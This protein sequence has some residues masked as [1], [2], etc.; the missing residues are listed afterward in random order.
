[1]PPTIALHAVQTNKA[2][3]LIKIFVVSKIV[4]KIRGM[5]SSSHVW[6]S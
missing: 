6:Q 5:D 4:H 2:G 1:M 3:S